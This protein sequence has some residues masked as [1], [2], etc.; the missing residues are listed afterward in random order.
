MREYKLP[1]GPQLHPNQCKLSNQYAHDLITNEPS[2]VRRT[3][4]TKPELADLV[5]AEYSPQHIF[6]FREVKS[7]VN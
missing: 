7:E 6:I 3:E 1:S 4:P 2:K 5:L